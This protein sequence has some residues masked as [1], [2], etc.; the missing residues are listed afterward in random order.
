MYVCMGMCV[1]WPLGSAAHDLRPRD[2]EQEVRVRLHARSVEPEPQSICV[3]FR[4][5][6]Q[7]DE[8]R[9]THLSVALQCVTQ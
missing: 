2:A 7:L 1:G 9:P 8:G 3:P 5:R 6:L 4:V